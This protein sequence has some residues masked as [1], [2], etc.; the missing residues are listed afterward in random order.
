MDPEKEARARKILYIAAAAGLVGLLLAVA[1]IFF[2]SGSSAD[3]VSVNDAMVTAGCTL[4]SVEAQ[5]GDHTV[6]SPEDRV[7]TWNTFPPT[8]GPHYVDAAVFGQYEEPLSQAQVVHNLEHGGIAIQYGSDVPQEIVAE[9]RGFYDE[10]QNGT[11]LAPLPELGRTIAIGAWVSPGGGKSGVGY[12]AKCAAFDEEAYTT[13]FDEFQFK[14]PERF[15]ADSL[16][17]GQ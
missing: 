7:D 3:A 17:P 8:N 15:S 2:G 14:G 1:L 5:E 16:R 13:F 11:L 9:L 4:V 12:L 6:G 10:H